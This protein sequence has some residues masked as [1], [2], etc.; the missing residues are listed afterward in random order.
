M[1]KIICNYRDISDALNGLDSVKDQMINKDSK[2]WSPNYLNAMEF[3][4]KTF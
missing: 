1:A 4:K 3:G 2:C